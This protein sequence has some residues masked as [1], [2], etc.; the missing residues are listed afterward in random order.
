MPTCTPNAEA[1]LLTRRV[2]SSESPPRSKKL[3]S[4]PTRSTPRTSANN[5][6]RISS[7]AV[8][9]PRTP[10]PNSG[11]GNARRSTFPFAVS[12]NASSTTTAD[13]TM[14]EGSVTLSD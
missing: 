1:T 11:T 12:G 5:P 3:S 2:A 13:G 9:G 7:P 14:Y 6:A 10:P 8:D 4:T